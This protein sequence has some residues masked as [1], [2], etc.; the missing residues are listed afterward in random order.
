MKWRLCVEID[1]EESGSLTNSHYQRINLFD[2]SSSSLGQD[3]SIQ[4]FT[5]KNSMHSNLVSLA[6]TNSSGG[7]SIDLVD[8]KLPPSNNKADNFLNNIRIPGIIIAVVL[9]FGYNLWKKGSDR[10]SKSSK[11]SR[12]ASSKEIETESAKYF[13][14]L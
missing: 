8:I 1:L 2:L 14:Q 10:N 3:S 6:F 11:K 4:V 5:N 9:V 13:L 7:S 12:S